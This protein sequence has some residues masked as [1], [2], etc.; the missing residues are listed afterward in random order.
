MKHP[1]ATDLVGM[2]NACYFPVLWEFISPLL[3]HLNIIMH[4]IFLVHM[5]FVCLFSVCPP[6][7]QPRNVTVG[8]YTL[9]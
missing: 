4:I 1:M 5:V 6:S 2:G 7:H 9:V 3:Y 8:N